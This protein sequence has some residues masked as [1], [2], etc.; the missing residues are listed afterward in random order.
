ME[1]I[2]RKIAEIRELQAEIDRRTE[3]ED[4]AEE[5]IGQCRFGEA[6]ELLGALEGAEGMVGQDETA[7]GHGQRQAEADHMADAVNRFAGLLSQGR[8]YKAIGLWKD[9]G[10]VARKGRRTTDEGAIRKKATKMRGMEDAELVH[11]VEDRVEKARSEGFREGARLTEDRQI[12]DSKLGWCLAT[13]V[14]SYDRS[15][16]LLKRIGRDTDGFKAVMDIASLHVAQWI[17]WRDV[18][19]QIDG[20]KYIF[21][22]RDG[23]FGIYTEDENERRWLLK[24][25]RKEGTWDGEGEH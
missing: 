10:G 13:F 11:Y 21:M 1:R 8:I 23:Y 15:L 18:L 16:L 4:R 7:L 14:A 19:E 24:V 22:H 25:E 6:E 2:D 17:A 9:D 3:A 12:M 20:R 5:L